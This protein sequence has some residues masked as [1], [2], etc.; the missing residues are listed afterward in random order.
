M[1]TIIDIKRRRIKN[2]PWFPVLMASL[3]WFIGSW[4]T[5]FEGESQLEP[6]GAI[7]R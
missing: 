1:N 5:K 7:E 4:I 6:I 3:G 2:G